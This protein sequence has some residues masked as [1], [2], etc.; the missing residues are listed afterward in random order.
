MHLQERGRDLGREE[1]KVVAEKTVLSLRNK[2]LEGT[3]CHLQVHV[4]SI[5]AAQE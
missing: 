3:F 5:H 4:I 1:C 2:L